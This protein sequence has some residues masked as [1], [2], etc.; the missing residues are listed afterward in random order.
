MADT[1][2]ATVPAAK[3]CTKCGDEKAVDAFP[4]RKNRGG[5]RPDS[6]CRECQRLAK[7]D[8]YRRNREALAAKQRLK[9][10]TNSEWRAARLVKTRERHRRTFT[11][12]GHRAGHL[13]RNY[14][15]TE[16]QY[17]AMVIAQ[18]GVCAVCRKPETA[19]EPR[20]GRPRLLSVDHDHVSGAVR[21]L[22]CRKCNSALGLLQEDAELVS[23]L[24]AYVL[25]GG[26]G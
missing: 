10:R 8:Y 4:I 19:V 25:R 9:Y 16:P 13:R 22:L 18:D 11:P 12:Q 20:S 6:W 17:E 5:G 21:G 14:G 23:Q 26:P 2:L 7:A 15:L 3:H 24:L 1:E